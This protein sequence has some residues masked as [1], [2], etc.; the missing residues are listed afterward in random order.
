MSIP[1]KFSNMWPRLSDRKRYTWK[2]HEPRSIENKTLKGDLK[3]KIDKKKT[4]VIR[5]WGLKLKS[6]KIFFTK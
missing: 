5:E 4:I 6:N 3:R 1:I 2:Y